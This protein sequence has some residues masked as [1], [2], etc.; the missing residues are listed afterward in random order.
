[1]PASDG[2]RLI[3]IDGS[4]GEGGGQILRTALALSMLS[5]RPLHLTNIRAGRKKPGLM[6][7][8]LA[9]VRAATQVCSANVFG[10]AL[11]STELRFE[12]GTLQAGSYQLSVGSAGST[13]LVLQTIFPALAMCTQPSSVRITGGTHNPLA[14][15]TDFLQNVFAPLAAKFGFRLDI[16]LE[17]HGFA[18]AGG[19]CI[20]ATIQPV[21][22]LRGVELI[23]RRGKPT[24]A[25]RIL[26][27]QLPSSIGLRE[28]KT[29]CRRLSIHDDQTSVAAVDSSGPGNAVLISAMYENCG[30]LVCESGQLGV[31]AER[32][33][34]VATDHMRR[35]IASSAP[36]GVH[37]ADQIMLP[38]AIAAQHGHASKLLIQDWSSHCDTHQAI[39][40]AML[41][42]QFSRR[43]V[44][45]AHEVSI[46]PSPNPP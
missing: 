11:T 23:T 40:E 3:Q 43:P 20:Q 25:A 24:Y 15:S 31:K 14:P 22:R 27:S 13:S 19:G 12:P 42:V 32:V 21:E 28:I 38:A 45:D 8:H 29:V 39:I 46:T 37:L 5:G 18:P 16:D 33:A 17:R 36:I 9:C 26:L 30:E 2:K 44:D 10:D 6:R 7:Q 34:R 4:Q 1:M 41:D 35:Y